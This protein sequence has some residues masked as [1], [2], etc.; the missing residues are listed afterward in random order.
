MFN[1]KSIIKSRNM[2]LLILHF[3]SFIP[4]KTM[5]K[6]Q[7]RIKL[8]QSLN[9]KNPQRFTEKLQWYKLYYRDPLM[10]QCVDK[11]D[12]REYVKDCGL[13]DILVPIVGVFDK[14]EDVNFNKLPDKFVV[15]D[16]LGGG[17]NSVV[18][19][20]DKNRI[21]ATELKNKMS[22][23][24]K[25]STSFRQGGREWV[26]GGKKHRIIIEHF[27]P[28]D[29]NKGGLIDYKFFCFNGE[30][31]YLYIIA[32]RVVGDKAG[33]AIYDSVTFENLNVERCDEKPLQREVK[34]PE[35]YDEMYKVAQILSKP[36]PEARID[37]YCVNNKVYFGEITF[38]DGSGYMRFKPDSFDYEIGKAF[39]LPERNN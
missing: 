38:F 28:S 24:V 7:Y 33:F 3:L 34:K 9:L 32:D 14:P 1:Y 15:K 35:V 29:P 20:E 26:Y 4:D 23:W 21:D 36:F 8:N 22:K 11:F 19:C 27:L 30:P 18:I 2:R 10:S 12:V 16:T 37:L 39:E 13:E 5:I 17:G 6:I 31:K 25:S